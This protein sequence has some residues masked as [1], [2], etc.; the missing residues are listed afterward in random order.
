MRMLRCGLAFLVLAGMA[1][2]ATLGPNQ[3]VQTPAGNTVT[4]GPAGCEYDVYQDGDTEV[5]DVVGDGVEVDLNRTDSET[6]VTGDGTTVNHN[7]DS[8]SSDVQGDNTTVNG[9]SQTNVTQGESSPRAQSS[10]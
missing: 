9:A 2:G 7:A 6:G 1:L 4:A 5:I 8:T 3:S 10:R